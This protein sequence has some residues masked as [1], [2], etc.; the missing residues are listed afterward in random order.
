MRVSTKHKFVFVSTMK[1]GT[2]TIYR[3]LDEHYAAGLHKR[4]F[5]SNEIPAKFAGFYRWTM[6]R[7]PY[8]R[9]ISLWWSGCRLAHKDQY[10]FREKC[11]A[12]DDFTRF[13][14]WLAGTSDKDRQHEPLMLNQ[15]QWLAPAEPIH[16]VKIEDAAAELPKLP[17]WKDGIVIPQLNTT[18]QKIVDQEEREGGKIMRPP[19]A[20]L[21]TRRARDAVLRWAAPDFKRFGYTKDLPCRRS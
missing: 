4:A 2:H 17:F 15:T 7:N 1:A 13:I 16:A 11:G 8:T 20:E 14:E 6:C 10:H 19:D 21:L 18:A 9:A 5:H 3:I 12:V